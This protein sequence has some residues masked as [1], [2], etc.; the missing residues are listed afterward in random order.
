MGQRC[1]A[2]VCASGGVEGI[3]I[4]GHVSRRLPRR[5]YGFRACR[6]WCW[7]SNQI[8][9]LRIRICHKSGFVGLDTESLDVV[10]LLLMSPGLALCLYGVSSIP[11]EGTVNSPKVYGTALAGLVLILAFAWWSMRPKHPLLDLRLLANRQF[12]VAAL[13]M[14]LFA[15]AFFGGLLLMPTYFQQ[16]R[17]DLLRLGDDL[18]GRLDHRRPADRDRARAVRSG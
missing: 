11:E 15:A 14:F 8:Y 9:R 10:G 16:V 3:A 7:K 12:S 13:T 18:L 4:Y 17:G 1:R 2:S 5:L 6:V